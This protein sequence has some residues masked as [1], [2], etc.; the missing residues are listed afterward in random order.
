M[1][2]TDPLE[3][4]TLDELATLLKVS[5]ATVLNEHDRDPH[6]PRYKRIGRQYRFKRQDVAS[7][8][9]DSRCT[10]PA[11]GQVA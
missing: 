6:F 3:Q 11:P 8:L 9:A 1:E 10:S 2:L 5:R 7:Y 4:M